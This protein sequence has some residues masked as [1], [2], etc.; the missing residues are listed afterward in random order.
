MESSCSFKLTKGDLP[1]WARAGF[2]P[3]FDA[4]PFV[5]SK[6][7][8]LVGVLFSYPMKSPG[9]NKILWVSQGHAGQMD[10]AAQLVG[11]SQVVDVGFVDVGPSYVNMPTPGCWHLTLDGVGWTDTIDLAYN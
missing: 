9:Q 1:V 8:D 10:I 2:S 11:T 7:G 5:T 6:H 4:T 3:P